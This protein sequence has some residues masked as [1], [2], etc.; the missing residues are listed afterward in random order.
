M[1]FKTSN[2]YE[3]IFKFLFK[4]QSIHNEST[5]TSFSL[6]EFIFTSKGIGPIIAKQ[7][8]NDV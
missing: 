3:I 5:K 2:L 1:V 8:Q 7:L 6:L 4:F